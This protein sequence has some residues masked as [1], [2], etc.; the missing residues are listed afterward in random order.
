MSDTNT[1]G[2][3]KAFD[4]WVTTF[5]G[6]SN[7][8]TDQIRLSAPVAINFVTRLCENAWDILS[9][10]P[11]DSVANGLEGIFL[12]SSD[13]PPNLLVED[14][15]WPDRKRCAK[16][17]FFLFEQY[18]SRKCAPLFGT[19]GT[20]TPGLDHICFMWWDRFPFQ[21]SPA[22][23]SPSRMIGWELL[24]VMRLCLTLDS[25]ACWES[26]LHGLNHWQ[27]DYP[28][29]VAAYVD[30]FLA[31]NPNLNSELRAYALKARQGDAQ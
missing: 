26:G 13:Y 12:D 23:D 3:T 14:V 27:P 19:G 6:G 9:P 20:V 7:W 11:D 29:E 15:P 24:E 21:C 22:G 10:F 1:S 4:Q 5:F 25:P 28:S 30:D 18:F 2:P 8:P 17:M 16:S 31:R